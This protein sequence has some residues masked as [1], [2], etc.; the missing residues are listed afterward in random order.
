MACP[1]DEVAKQDTP[2]VSGW[3][4]LEAENLPNWASAVFLEGALHW[5]RLAAE[6]RHHLPRRR[7]AWLC[8]ELLGLE[9][10][11][12]WDLSPWERW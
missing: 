2:L 12:L 8:G 5:V 11:P 3:S 1:S 9:A 7:L 4:T 6:H 10:Y